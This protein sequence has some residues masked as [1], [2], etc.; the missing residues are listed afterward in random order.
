[1]AS[2]RILIMNLA[3]IIL[4]N[5]VTKQVIWSDILQSN[6]K[7][8]LKNMIWNSILYASVRYNGT[9]YAN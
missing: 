6:Y 4:I 1:M 3:C 7:V 2:M 5:T 8:R 9:L